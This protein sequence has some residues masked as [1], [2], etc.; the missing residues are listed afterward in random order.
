MFQKICKMLCIWDGDR[1]LNLEPK[2][3]ILVELKLNTSE[4]G[5][6]WSHIG[7]HLF[8]FGTGQDCSDVLKVTSE[9]FEYLENLWKSYKL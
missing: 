8:A 5:R 3:C 6:E 7:D 4:K 2:Q 9:Q 1:K